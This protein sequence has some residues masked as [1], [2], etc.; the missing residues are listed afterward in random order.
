MNMFHL[1]GLIISTKLAYNR[2]RSVGIVG[3]LGALI[4]LGLI[5]LTVFKWESI[6]QFLVWSGIWGFFESME[7]VPPGYPYPTGKLL[8][9]IFVFLPLLFF[10]IFAGGGILFFGTLMILTA[11]KE[12]LGDKIFFTL[13]SILFAP[14]ILPI[15]YT[16]KG[17]RKLKIVFNPE[18]RREV[19]E[20]KKKEEYLR[21]NP[22]A[23]RLI[24]EGCT[25]ISHKEAE[26]RL[27]RLPTYGDESFLVGTMDHDDNR[28][29]YVLLPRPLHT[30]DYLSVPVVKCSI[31]D[32]GTPHP[33]APN[34]KFHVYFDY[35]NMIDYEYLSGFNKIYETHSLDLKFAFR[36]INVSDPYR[37]YV[38]ET[39]EKYFKDKDELLNKIKNMD[40]DDKAEYEKTVVSLKSY[41]AINE[42]VVR[43]MWE[44]ATSQKG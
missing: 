38:K 8:F 27:N 18:Y 1:L 17:I 11:L 40:F 43:I 5:L 41:D 10:V 25:P 6:H 29:V 4:L 15:E 24:R 19:L 7:L 33:K 30:D 26:I 35:E 23:K 32:W 13:L 44:S 22:P 21:K 42:E 14:I 39:Q 28:Y 34:R 36:F 31:S 37:V 3:L 2:G 9:F 16:A 12:I 20:R